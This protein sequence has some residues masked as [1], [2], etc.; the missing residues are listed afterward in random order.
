MTDI[1]SH[2]LYGTD[3]G[4]K[5]LD[6]SIDILRDMKNV[7]Y[8]N[9]IITPH[10]IKDSKYKSSRK[11]NLEKLEIMRM[12]LLENNIDINIYLGNEIFIDEDIYKLL[13]SNIISP[14]NDTNYLLIEIPL[15]GIYDDYIDIFKDLIENGYNIILAHPERY[16]AFQDDFNKIYE[17]EKLGVYFQSNIDSITGRYGEKAQKMIKRLLKEKKIAFL[18]TDI[19]HK[20]H[21]YRKW[22]L[23]K[24]IALKYISEKEYDLL[25]NKNPSQLID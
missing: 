15:S 23:A 4:T 22:E 21:D 8:E 5:T 17:L 13:Q 1:H 2:L 6:E 11:E 20:K 9:V 18:A 10:Y 7:G 14:L 25:V 24:K 3:D 12:V 16:L 19:H